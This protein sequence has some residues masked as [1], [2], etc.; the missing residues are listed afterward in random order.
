MSPVFFGIG[1]GLAF[2]V[3]PLLFPFSLLGMAGGPFGRAPRDPVDPTLGC[4]FGLHSFGGPSMSGED[5][6]LEMPRS[7]ATLLRAMLC[8]LCPLP[9]WMVEGGNIE[10]LGWFPGDEELVLW[11]SNAAAAMASA[12]L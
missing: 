6:V 9:I 1:G 2:P 12:T 7:E 3:L 4:G 11:A 5:A 10:L 8:D